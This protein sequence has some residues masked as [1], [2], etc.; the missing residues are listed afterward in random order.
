MKAK[1]H[2]IHDDGIRCLGVLLLN[3]FR[4]YTVER[5]WLDNTPF[6]SCIPTGVYETE[7]IIRP[8]G[9]PAVSLNNVPGRTHILIHPGNEVYDV[10]GCI[11]P[12]M[13]PFQDGVLDSRDAMDVLLSAGI[14]EI[15]IC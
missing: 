3:D 14:T 15:E 11:A 12:G 10:V 8:S 5:P 6:K 7:N 9:K 13:R 2:R 4:C 1:L